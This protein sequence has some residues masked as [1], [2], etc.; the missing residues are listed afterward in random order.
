LS[1][2]FAFL[3]ITMATSVV[4]KI[5]IL[6]VKSNAEIDWTLLLFE[7]VSAICSLLFLVK[8]SGALEDARLIDPCRSSVA[9]TESDASSLS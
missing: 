2:H 4:Q 7:A 6:R 1:V 3:L 8:T 9:M 5:T